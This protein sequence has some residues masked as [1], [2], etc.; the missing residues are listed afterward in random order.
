MTPAAPWSKRAHG[1]V[2][3]FKEKLWIRVAGGGI[4]ARR[5]ERRVVLRGW[6]PLDSGD[7]SSP[8][9]AAHLVFGACPRDRLWVLGGWSKEHGNFGD[10]WCS[11]NG[12]D[13]IE[14]RS[15]VI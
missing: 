13:W 2:V 9:G 7:G 8:L 3:V 10:V 14:V 5:D 4:R 1:Q 15:N 11:E 6:R 12:R